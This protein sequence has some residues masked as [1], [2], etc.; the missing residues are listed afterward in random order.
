MGRLY[1]LTRFPVAVYPIVALMAGASTF[2]AWY[3]SRLARGPEVVWSKKV[4][5]PQLSEPTA[6]SGC[7]A[8]ANYKVFRL[9]QVF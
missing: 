9:Q 7:E 2:A 1:T 3:V 8:R 6:L 4:S 5:V